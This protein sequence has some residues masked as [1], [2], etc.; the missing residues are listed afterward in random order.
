MTLSEYLRGMGYTPK[1]EADAKEI[2]DDLLKPERAQ[3]AAWQDQLAQVR[4]MKPLL[5]QGE[6]RPTGM[7]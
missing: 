3:P 5:M 4:S 1:D 7:L 2:L 6:S